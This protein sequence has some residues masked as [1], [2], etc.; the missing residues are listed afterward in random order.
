MSNEYE[1]YLRPLREEDAR[2]SWRWRNN[3]LVWKMTISHPSCVV[4]Q[5]MELDWI[6]TVLADPS[7]R[8]YAI[9]LKKTDA[10]VGNV[11]LVNI[12]QTGEAVESIFI[13]LPELWGKG[14]GTR[15][16][17]LL[18]EIARDTLGIKVIHSVIRI[19]NA[20]SMKSVFKCGFHVV[21][22]DEAKGIVYLERKLTESPCVR[23]LSNESET[24]VGCS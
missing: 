3:P 8:N 21:S 22:R 13:G 24:G 9:C 4:T 2:V 17:E 16:R 11:Y 12:T 14:I 15:A 6:R 7:R 20:A 5:A 18:Y 19:E 23:D 10:Y 1:V